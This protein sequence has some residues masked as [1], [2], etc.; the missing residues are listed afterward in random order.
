MN[1]NNTDYNYKLIIALKFQN[2]MNELLSKK[3]LD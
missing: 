1:E 3:S 2:D